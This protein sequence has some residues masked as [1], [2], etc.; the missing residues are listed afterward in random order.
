SLSDH[1]VR[2]E[3]LVFRMEVRD[4]PSPFRR[5]GDEAADL[6]DQRNETF[7]DAPTGLRA[8]HHAL[9]PAYRRVHRSS[10]RWFWFAAETQ[11]ATAQS[12]G[13][14]G[15]GPLAY[16]AVCQEG[17]DEIA[18]GPAGQLR[19]L[20]SPGCVISGIPGVAAEAATM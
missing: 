1:G 17:L 4:R 19:Y 2:H 14:D 12:I 15:F 10:T 3:A 7:A 11:A 16:L 20:A 8:V 5:S 9:I 13:P 18:D 6:A